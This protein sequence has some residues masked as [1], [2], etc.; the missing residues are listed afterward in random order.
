MNIT[1]N[2]TPVKEYAA[3]DNLEDIV[4]GL[5]KSAVPENHL[6]GTIRVNGQEYS[7]QYPGESRTIDKRSIDNL[8]ID[9]VSVKTYVSAALKD[10][11]ILLE[12]IIVSSRNT[13]ELF[14]MGDEYEAFGHYAN[15]LESLRAFIQFVNTAAQ[16]TQWD[17]ALKSPAGSSVED[18]WA[19][20]QEIIDELGTVQD[21][22]DLIL[23]ADLLEYELNPALSRW[24]EIFKQK[25]SL[26]DGD[27]QSKPGLA[28]QQAQDL[29]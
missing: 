9:T 3:A 2:G 25:A 21:E 18:E 11:D 6:V 28:P 20:I 26:F 14:R 17:P 12:R 24:Q 5:S 29:G 7:E 10:T 4:V 19:R 22:G 15:L 23:V 27:V 1:I 13:A 16:T 8:E